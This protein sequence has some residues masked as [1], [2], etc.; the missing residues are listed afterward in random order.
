[1]YLSSWSGGKDSCFAC[2]RAIQRGYKISYLINFISEE[3]KRVSFHGM[4]ARLIKL[5]AE[6]AGIQL[7][8]DETT[9]D[10]YEQE[11]KNTVQ[12]LI[13]QGIK[14]MVF[15]D[16]YLEEQKQWVERVCGDLG[17]EAIE[18]LWKIDTE[19]TMNDFVNEGFE[20]VVVSSQKKFIGKEW[21]GRKVNR[22]FLEYLK[23]KP[24]VDICGENGEYHTFVV[25]GPL[26]KGRIDITQSQIIERNGYWFLDIKDFRVVNG[27]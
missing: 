4:E 3:Y 21:I 10:G 19:K 23:T 27:E 2:Y 22:E 20:A 15:G 1:M 8:Q 6:L 24:G 18:P 17:I 7:V 9:P 12:S 14:G 26:F 25:G 13:P 16:L 11:F 5:Q